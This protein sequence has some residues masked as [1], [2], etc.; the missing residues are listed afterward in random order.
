MRRRGRGPGAIKDRKLSPM[1][2]KHKS[3]MLAST[4]A[5]GIEID[6]LCLANIVGPLTSGPA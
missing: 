2:K 5:I 3:G 4:N 6:Q 1:D